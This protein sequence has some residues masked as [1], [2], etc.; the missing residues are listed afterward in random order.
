MLAS[1]GSGH[2][3]VLFA[4]QI[5]VSVTAPNALLVGYVFP[6]EQIIYSTAQSGPLIVVYG[7][8]PTEPQTVLFRD[9]FLY[10]N[11]LLE[12]SWTVDRYTS[13][14]SNSGEYTSSGYLNM[15]A[16]SVGTDTVHVDDPMYSSGI[17]IVQTTLNAAAIDGQAGNFCS[18]ATTCTVTLSTSQ[19][20]DVVI[21]YTDMSSGDTLAVS[22]TAGLSWS[23]RSGL[24]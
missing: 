12:S 4:G 24:E 20:N 7:A 21:L 22:D 3:T 13:P 17:P 9:D 10:T 11:P 23:S 16:G 14:G 1:N 8:H 15:K 18:S 2:L 5:P 19:P 6:S